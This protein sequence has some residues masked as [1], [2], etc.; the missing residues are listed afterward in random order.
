VI[1]LTIKTTGIVTEIVE[2]IEP[3]EI[4]IDLCISFFK[5]ARIAVI[6]SGETIIMAI[7]SPAMLS[8]HQSKSMASSRVNESDS[9]ST[10]ITPI[11]INNRSV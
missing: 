5:D 2:R 8:G 7:I 10:E 6:P 1:K 9:A 4:F 3:S 11:V